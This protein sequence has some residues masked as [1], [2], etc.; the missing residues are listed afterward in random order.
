MII[1]LNAWCVLPRQIYTAV[2]NRT[3]V[4][5]L[6]GAIYYQIGNYDQCITFND[7][8]ILLN[9]HMAEA[10]ANLANAL[11]QIGNLDMAIIYYQVGR[12]HASWEVPRCQVWG[13]GTG[14]RSDPHVHLCSTPSRHCALSRT[15][16]TRTITWL[17]LWFRRAW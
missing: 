9:P 1:G 8:C 10:H 12:V 11:Q 3:D 17:A 6:I 14:E 7:R 13:C 2:P 15:S 16:R 5:L 4:L